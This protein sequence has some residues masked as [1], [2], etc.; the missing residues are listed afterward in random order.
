MVLKIKSI[1]EEDLAK[2]LVKIGVD[3]YNLVKGSTI[4]LPENKYNAI[5]KAGSFPHLGL[6]ISAEL[7]VPFDEEDEGV[8]NKEYNSL[9]AHLSSKFINS[10]PLVDAIYPG[11]CLGKNVLIYGKGG[12]GKSQMTEFFMEKALDLGM[13][14]EEPFVVAF[15]E[16][17][18]EEMLF[19]GLDMKEITETGKYV[20]LVENS[21][22]NH[23]TVIIEEIFDAPPQV[24][25][26]L[27]D[28]M[29]SGYFRKGAQTFKC[30]T[31][32]IIALTNKSKEEFAEDNSLEALVQRFQVTTKLEWE[33]YEVSTWIS[34]FKKVFEESF[35]K[36]NETKLRDL[37]EIFKINNMTGNTFVSPR[38][39]VAAAEIYCFGS[40]LDLISDIDQEIVK[41]YFKGLKVS[42]KEVELDAAFSKI[43]AYFEAISKFIGV[44]VEKEDDDEELMSLLGAEEDVVVK[45]DVKL[46]PNKIAVGKRKCMLLNEFISGKN[47]E[48]AQQINGSTVK[49][50]TIDRYIKK[51]E[52]TYSFLDKQEKK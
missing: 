5:K 29:T 4:I 1:K 20:Y 42:E 7:L 28:I 32:R 23:E 43:E 22:M 33:D 36:K 46:T 34:L 11:L 27:K 6:N 18:T 52:K 10:K 45:S 24:L 50:N 26:S 8:T 13:I 40:S 12:F 35:Y 41:G 25:L 14:S 2:L 47:S 9:V 49:K 39:A 30:R 16:G 51:V 44:D 31:K 38:T 48:Y 37:A 15:G 17:L 19:G 21:F 3:E